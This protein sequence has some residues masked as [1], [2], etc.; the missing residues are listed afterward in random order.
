MANPDPIMRAAARS[1]HPGGV[2]VLMC[3]GSI[4]FVSDSIESLIW[5]GAGSAEGEE[6]DGVLSN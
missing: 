6:A 2:N 5:R 3:D 1:R 4:H